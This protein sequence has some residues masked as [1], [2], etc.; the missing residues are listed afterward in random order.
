MC[1]CVCVCDALILLVSQLAGTWHVGITSLQAHAVWYIRVI[2]LFVLVC[3]DFLVMGE[4]NVLTW[5]CK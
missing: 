2:I 4:A 5:T 3:V 1:V